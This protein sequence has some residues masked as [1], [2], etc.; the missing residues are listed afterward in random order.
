MADVACVGILCAD[1]LV[2]P[3]IALPGKG[4]LE[5]VDH[6]QLDIGGCAANAAIDLARLGISTTLIGKV[7]ADAFG[8]Y[9]S[10]HLVSEGVDV[11]YLA[12]DHRVPTSASVVIIDGEGERTILHCSGANASFQFED[13]NLEEVRRSKFLFIA[14]TF[15][16]KAFDGAGAARLLKEAQH[17]GKVCFCDT[18][19][20]S[21]GL[22]MTTIE[23]ML[24]YV[25]WFMPSFDEAV[26]LSGE[27]DPELIAAVFKG[28]GV[29]NVVIKLGEKGCYVQTENEAGFF[30][31]AFKDIPVIDTSGAG[32]SFCAG[33]IAG[34]LN[35]FDARGCALLANAAGA[36]CVMQMGTTSGIRTMQETVR[37][38]EEHDR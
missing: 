5:L 37:F 3:V 10:N 29:K 18:A 4:K 21:S 19:W 35:G 34:M 15:L 25:D 9:L 14:G 27:S 11:R 32:D 38:I 7:G 22:W 26:Q 17:A 12:V 20:D 8:E 23:C 36:Q 30:V 2:K 33:F 16:M 1:V 6:L 13:V 24:P 31:P 28:K